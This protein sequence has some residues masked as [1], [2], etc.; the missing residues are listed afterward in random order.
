MLVKYQS[1]IKEIPIDEIKVNVYNPRERFNEEE[2]EELI[3]SILE[4]GILNPIIVYQSGQTNEYIILDGER[5]FR[6]CQK[7]NISSIPARILLKEPSVLESL[8]LMFHV[9]NVREDWTEFAIS[10]T[11]KRII[12]EMGKDLKDLDPYDIKEL[13]RMTSL[14][15]YKVKKYLKFQDYPQDVINRFLTS[16]ITGKKDSGPDPDILLEMHRP[17]Q[18]IKEQMPTILNQYSIYNIIDSCINKKENGIIKNNKEFRLIS[19]SLSAA[20]RGE[21]D[22]LI[23]EQNLESFFSNINYTPSMLFH[24]TAESLYKYKSTLK[25]SQSLIDL[26]TQ[27]DFSSLDNDKKQEIRTMFNELLQMISRINNNL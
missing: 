7:L 9:H 8:S 12:S 23:L 27:T 2:E 16:E 4:K 20:K 1:K 6:A 10:I 22:S 13:S 17:I 21:I 26:I 15:P 14:S 5:R 19:Q 18:E 25:A 3:E 11:I 24:A